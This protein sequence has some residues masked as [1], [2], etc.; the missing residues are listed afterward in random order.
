MAAATVY[1]A[2]TPKGERDMA[3]VRR[4]QGKYIFVMSEPTVEYEVVDDLTTNGQSFMW[5]KKSIDD[6]ID[7]M[8]KRGMKRTEK[9]EIGEWDAILT[10]DGTRGALIKFKE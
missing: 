8:I 6:Q 2:A 10:P 7:H 4:I 5:G 9:G 3:K 1:T